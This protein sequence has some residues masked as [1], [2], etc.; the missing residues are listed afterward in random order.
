M[1]I[2]SY[3]G[4]DECVEII[5]VRNIVLGAYA[6]FNNLVILKKKKKRFKQ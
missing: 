2:V 5:L 1:I 3:L 4:Y 6:L